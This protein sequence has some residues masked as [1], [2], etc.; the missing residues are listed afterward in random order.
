MALKIHWILSVIR[1]LFSIS[2][3]QM[4]IQDEREERKTFLET[5]KS[6]CGLFTCYL[7]PTMEENAH[8]AP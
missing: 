1:R 8:P 2:Y 7:N 4:R 6:S 5:T 3:Q